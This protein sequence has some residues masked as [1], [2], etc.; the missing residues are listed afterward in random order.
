[1]S[2]EDPKVL[3]EIIA[4]L[5]NKYGAMEINKKKV[6]TYVGMQLCFD[7]P[8]LVR[9]DMKDYIIESIN[10]FEEENGI[11]GKPASSPAADHI[12]KVYNSE[13]KLP[14]DR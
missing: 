9:I 11:V 1:M 13:E 10:E 14:Q 5:E 2:H 3:D 8:S 12:F 4:K 7:T 6:Q